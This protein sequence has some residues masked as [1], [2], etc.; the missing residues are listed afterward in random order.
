MTLS[1]KKTGA[2][3]FVVQFL[4]KCEMEGVMYFSLEQFEELAEFL[5]IEPSVQNHS[6]KILKELFS[7]VDKIDS[8]LSQASSHWSVERMGLI[9]R[10]I[11]RQAVYEMLNQTAPVKV[12]LNEAVNLAK[13][14][15]TEKSSAFVNGVLDSVAKNI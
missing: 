12:I 13:K 11:L 14:F 8:M 5:E 2:R 1:S 10:V 7:Q 15:G 4:Y 3:E 9:D 6:L